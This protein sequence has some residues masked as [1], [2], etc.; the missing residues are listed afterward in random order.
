MVGFSRKRLLLIVITACVALAA[1][2]AQAFVFTHLEHDCVGED[3]P[4][5]LQIET[6]LSLLKG[7]GLLGAIAFAGVAS[8]C[9]KIIGGKA[10]SLY[11]GL[12]TPVTLKVK[13]SF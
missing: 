2:F 4:V 9:S 8:V 11:I 3:C 5:C 1:V 13:L 6:A 7:L 12:M 10:N